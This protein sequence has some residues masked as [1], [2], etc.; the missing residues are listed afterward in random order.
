[1]FKP[2]RGIKYDIISEEELTKAMDEDELL[3]DIA[4]RRIALQQHIKDLKKQV[5]EM[6]AKHKKSFWGLYKAEAA[7][8]K[9]KMKAGEKDIKL[10]NNWVKRTWELFKILKFKKLRHGRFKK[11]D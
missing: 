8:I 4:A 7:L 2:P 11:T 1:M 5:T 9:A 10:K 6:K 3:A